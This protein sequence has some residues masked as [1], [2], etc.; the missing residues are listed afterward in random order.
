MNGA[1]ATGKSLYIAV[2]IKQ[3]GHFMAT[4]NGTIHF[5]DA[6]TQETYKNIYEKPLFEARGLMPATPPAATH[7]SYVVE[8]L[9]FSLGI[10]NGVRRYLVIRD[11]AGEDM[12]K[13]PADTM[14]LA[15]LRHA[16]GVF[17][18]FDPLTVPDIR[19]KVQDL[20]PAQLRLGGDPNT[21]LSNL[22]NI[23]GTATPPLAVILSKFDA[24]QE[25]RN[26]DDVQ[27]QSVM[28]NSGAAFL[29]DPSLESSKYDQDDGELLHEE[30]RSLLHKLNAR[31]LVLSL[32]NPGAGQRIPYRFFAVSALGES[33]SGDAVHSRGIAPFRCLDPAKWVLSMTGA[34]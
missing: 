13:P 5:A 2:L 23:I 32:E 25:L 3:L 30:V 24:M 18:M 6:R 14:P 15:F 16:D 17:F 27:W 31:H 11:V 19:A 4:M 20:I 9:I 1:R 33:P 28:S 26:V 7:D 10:L 21:V 22:L 12:E 34:I 29:R 8:P